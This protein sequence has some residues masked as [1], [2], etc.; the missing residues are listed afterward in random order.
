MGERPRL[1]A[2]DQLRLQREQ[3]IT[4]SR[5]ESTWKQYEYAF[6]RFK[7]WAE[8]MRVSSLPCSEDVGQLYITFVAHSKQSVAAAI[9]AFAAI[10][11]FHERRGLVRP[12]QSKASKLILEG[13][14]RTFGKPSKQSAFLS[15]TETGAF[16]A[17]CLA[18][19]PSR[20]SPRFVR[21]G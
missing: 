3:L 1:P 13:I 6:N 15:P 20:A 9:S 11:A 21:A 16:V 12:L 2:L 17:V 19:S 18:A 7:K 8:E 5:A 10:N 4:S 14:R